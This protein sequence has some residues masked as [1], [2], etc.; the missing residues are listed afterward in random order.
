MK[1]QKIGIG[2]NFFSEKRKG[3]EEI[4]CSMNEI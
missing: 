4:D 3:K 1:F 2:Q